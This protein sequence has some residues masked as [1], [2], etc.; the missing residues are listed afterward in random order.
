MMKENVKKV[1]AELIDIQNTLKHSE[2][3]GNLPI[4]ECVDRMS[5]CVTPLLED[6]QYAFF[7]ASL[8]R[9]A[10]DYDDKKVELDFIK[11]YLSKLIELI[12]LTNK[13]AKSEE[14][15]AMYQDAKAVCGD[16]ASTVQMGFNTT[17]E[18][19]KAEGPRYAA[20][21]VSSLRGMGKKLSDGFKK[22]L[23]DDGEGTGD[24]EKEDG[25][26]E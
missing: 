5:A 24:G 19:I 17:K 9:Y 4:L 21:A 8:Q 11:E 14:A 13:P 25:G 1:Y 7:A 26:E 2:A 3:M 22:W 23:E 16:I 6:E 15:K 10:K 18:V 12:E 20:E